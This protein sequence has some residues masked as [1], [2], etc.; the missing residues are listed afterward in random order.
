M[1]KQHL[2]C[3]LLSTFSLKATENQEKCFDLG[4]GGEGGAGNYAGEG[5]TA[6]HFQ[7]RKFHQYFFKT[8]LF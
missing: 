6:G 5:G 2:K 7:I 1:K 3:P 4:F 8:S